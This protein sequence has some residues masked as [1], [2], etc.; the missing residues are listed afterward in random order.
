MVL[1]LAGGPCLGVGGSDLWS[2]VALT[3]TAVSEEDWRKTGCG[4][5]G[6]G[7]ITC[8]IVPC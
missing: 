6:W 8:L 3:V 4:V 5:A 1:Q 2:V 7:D